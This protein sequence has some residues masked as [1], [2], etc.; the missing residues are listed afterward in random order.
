M[1]ILLI[2]FLFVFSIFLSFKLKFKNY[3]LNISELFNKDRSSL[4]LN[5]ATKIG[6]GSVIGVASSIIIGGFS[7]IIWMIIFT[8][9]T[10][11]LIYY[12]AKLGNI[13]K[14]KINNTYISGPF[15]VLKNGLNSKI[16]SIISLLIIIILYSFLFQMIQINT[17]TNI[18]N[19]VFFVDKKYII[20]STIILLFLIISFDIIKVNRVINIIVPIKCIIFILICL[21]GII[22][23]FDEL[24]IGLKKV[25]LS[26]FTFKSFFTGLVI[27]IKRSIFM[28]EILIG[29]TSISSGCDN[30]NIKTSINYQ[31]IGVYFI[32][33]IL[34]I[35]IFFLLIIYLNNHSI[36]Y[37]YNL[38]IT[39]TFIYLNG[40]IGIYF[41]S[42]I[43]ILFAF[44]TILSGY[45]IL[46][47][48]FN[49]LFKNKKSLSIIKTIFILIIILGAFIDTGVLWKYTDTL[50]F[51]MIIINSYSIIRLLRK[52]IV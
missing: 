5:L 50:I 21:I 11:P 13:Y 40:K 14:E 44:T 46:I 23:N 19:N 18:L 30:N 28:N 37:D 39:N 43:L 2:I 31:I 45:Y 17:V 12:E 4:F 15:F 6:V 29:T 49:Y 33:F 36:I 25:F 48:N 9:I 22:S 27:G 52:V 35:L 24:I 16:I 42:I 47:S 32:T 20:I 38:L 41:I 7:S 8:I 3:K 26:L 34:T 10:N 51:I 1:W